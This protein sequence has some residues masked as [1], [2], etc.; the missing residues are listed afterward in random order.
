MTLRHTLM[1]HG[2][3]ALLRLF[4]WVAR[5]PRLSWLAQTMGEGMAHVVGRTRRLGQA[6][7]VAHLG[8]LWQRAFPSAKHVPIESVT[9]TTVIAQIHTHCPLRG[10]G[11]VH[12]CH[13]MMAFDRALVEGA[14]GQFIVIASQA[15]PGV[16]H[17]RVALRMAGQPVDDLVP[18]HLNPDT[19]HTET[20]P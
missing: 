9:H 12:A 3:Q 1:R 7:D 5:R 17:C 10:S 18:A 4:A 20:H 2:F 14:G 15:T 8:R 6:H 13:R 16:S 19:R 11:D